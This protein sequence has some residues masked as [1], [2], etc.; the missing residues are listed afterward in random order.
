MGSPAQALGV[1]GPGKTV[2]L[3]GNEWI[4]SPS[5]Q[6]MQIAFAEWL[7]GRAKKER[8]A[9]AADMRRRAV[10]LWA[11]ARRLQEEL[12]LGDGETDPVRKAELTERHE[13]AVNEARFLEFESIESLERFRRA[14]DAGDYEFYGTEGIRALGTTL[15]QMQMVWLMLKPKHPGVTFA[16]VERLHR[17]TFEL[18][19]ETVSLQ[20]VL[21]HRQVKS[22]KGTAISRIEL[23]QIC[24]LQADGL[25]EKKGQAKDPAPGDC[26]APAPTQSSSTGEST[27]ETKTTRE[28]SRPKS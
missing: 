26:P 4:L 16:E 19:G 12:E 25:F 15:G 8:D 24:L 7:K 27:S 9:D 6:G 21:E 28:R 11:E 17:G 13:A 10:P 18:D 20:D 1:N 22:L 23:W 14:R 2:R 5:T 3:D